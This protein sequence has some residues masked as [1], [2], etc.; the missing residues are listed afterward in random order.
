MKR[1][2]VR[3]VPCK[4]GEVVH[5]ANGTKVVL[6]GGEVLPR[7]TRIELVAEVNNVWRAKIECL[8]Q[9]P[10]ISAEA[11]FVTSKPL[12][13]W[14]RWLLWLAGVDAADV[15]SLSDEARVWQSLSWEQRKAAASAVPADGEGEA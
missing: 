9:A 3:I 15:T 4:A 11:E 2:L 12:T 14:R 7:V 1:D 10:E 13:R 5:T 6:P 8:V